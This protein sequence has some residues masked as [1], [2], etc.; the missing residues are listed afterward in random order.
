MRNIYVY[1]VINTHY[2]DAAKKKNSDD[3]RCWS[4]KTEAEAGAE[5][6]VELVQLGKLSYDP[7]FTYPHK[8]QL[9]TL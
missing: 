1:E 5:D 8:A 4:W 9:C 6:H 2:L 7:T 3:I